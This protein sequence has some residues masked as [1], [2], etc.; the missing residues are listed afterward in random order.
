[1]PDACHFTILTNYK[2]TKFTFQQKRDKC[3]TR[4]VKHLDTIS[5]FM[6]NI[7]QISGKDNIVDN[8]LFRIEEIT[9][10]VTHDKLATAQDDDY[11]LRKLLEANTAL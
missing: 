6:M 3:S 1:M 5:Q 2:A 9:P 4:H 10:P 7:R 8:A 11:E